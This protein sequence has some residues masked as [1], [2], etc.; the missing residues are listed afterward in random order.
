MQKRRGRPPLIRGGS[1]SAALCV[2]VPVYDH[3]ARVAHVHGQSLSSV[4]R[5]II[6]KAPVMADE[7]KHAE[8]TLMGALDMLELDIIDEYDRLSPEEVLTILKRVVYGLRM[9]YIEIID[10]DTTRPH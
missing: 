7:L 5:R 3:Y 8:W 10:S 6:S 2:S 1:V 4:L 9:T